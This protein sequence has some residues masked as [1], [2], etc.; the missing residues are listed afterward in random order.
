MRSHILW[1]YP[2]AHL[3]FYFFVGHYGKLGSL[4]LLSKELL[5]YLHSLLFAAVLGEHADTA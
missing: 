3:G 5:G 2:F 1:S 4:T